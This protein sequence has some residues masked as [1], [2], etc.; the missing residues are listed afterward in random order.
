MVNPSD[1]P[2]DLLL[3]AGIL[4]NPS[5]TEGLSEQETIRLI[6]LGILTLLEQSPEPSTTEILLT[7]ASSHP[8][9]QVKFTALQ[10]LERL[11]A[12]SNQLAIDALFQLALEFDST[13]ARQHI[14]ANQNRPSKSANYLLLQG[15]VTLESGTAIRNDELGEFTH[16]LLTHGG[17]SLQE[18]VLSLARATRL[19]YWADL[20]EI[21]RQETDPSFENILALYP[22]LSEIERSLA[23]HYL[24]RAA[25]HRTSARELICRLFTQYE[26]RAARDL[27]VN[28]GYIPENPT[29]KALFLFLTE[30]W[31]QYHQIDANHAALINAYETNH[32]A[33]RRRIL[34]V[35]RQSGQIEWLRE[36]SHTADIRWLGD[37][38]D[39]DW[40][41]TITRLLN[42]GR[43]EELWKLAQSAPAFWSV[44]IFESLNK[45]NWSPTDP[46]D[47]TAYSSLVSLALECVHHKLDLQPTK[48]F[49]ALSGDLTCLALNHSADLLTAGSMGQA[50]Y[51]WQ[52]P[53]GDL[54]LPAFMGPATTTRAIAFSPDSEYLAAASG[55]QRVRI[56][57][58]QNHQILKTLE[59]HRGLIR[60]LLIHPGGRVMVTAGFDGTVRFWRFPHGSEIKTVT[61]PV[62]EI[63]CLSL[64][65]RGDVVA[66][67]GAGAEISLWKIPEGTL[68]R[69]L[70]SPASGITHLAASSSSDLL[71]SAGR[72][73]SL[74]VWNTASGQIVRQWTDLPATIMGLSFH[75]DDQV[76]LSAGSDGWIT[77]WSIPTG[78][79][80]ARLKD[81]SGQ[82]LTALTASIDGEWLVSANAS[83]RL[84]LWNL[85]TFLWSRRANQPGNRIRLSQL[86]NRL[87][88]PTVSPGERPWLAFMIAINK[89][90]QRFDIELTETL[91]IP[92]GEFDIEI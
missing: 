62:K 46:S 58:L 55:D 8:D 40:E 89:F 4:H 87:E 49:H 63:F 60:A 42:N 52:L 86:T 85:S 53:E 22:S 6:Q 36:I 15:L 27:A 81:P 41:L 10:A 12:Q 69:Q 37:L 73:R 14:I 82:P 31:E 64:L 9:P 17:R 83:G 2:Q 67:A 80:I 39:P 29:E 34:A 57:R 71:A 72:D 44:K 20:I 91:T 33:I 76:I 56:F 38:T 11:S 21:L 18:R 65:H 5:D 23:L 48:T 13:A 79:M 7:T 43:F 61:A 54:Q 68:I 50:I 74:T 16:A 75:P 30:Q 84:Y 1:R 78:R 59:G 90:S 92:I 28:H 26:D 70:Y 3:L 19:R 32:R 47:Q 66:S 35:S 45:S 24:G 77:L 25:Q 51:I 88:Q